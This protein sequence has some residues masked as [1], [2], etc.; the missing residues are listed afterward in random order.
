MAHR[1]SK[2]R[3]VRDV[4]TANVVSVPTT[5]TVAE[6]ARAMRD[7]D[8]GDV[9]VVQDSVIVGILTDRD[10]VVRAVAEGRAVEATTVSAVCSQE[11]LALLAPDDAIGHA[12]D[13]MKRRAVRRLPVVEDGRP[14]GI[15]SLSDLALGRD[16]ESALGAVSSAPANR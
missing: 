7:R 10:I 4:M 15:V 14:V 16:R 5:A 12:V 6:A 2:K 8:I 11:E 13:L 3:T 9:V 1:I